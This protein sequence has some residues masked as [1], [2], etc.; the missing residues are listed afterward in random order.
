[1]V[2][3]KMNFKPRSIKGRSR[4]LYKEWFDETNQYRIVWTREVCGV[5]VPPHFF[6]TVR[7]VLPDGHEMWDFVG[8]RGPY[9]TFKKAIED[10]EANQRLWTRAM[11]ASGIRSLKDVFG[12]LPIGMPIWV[13]KKIRCDI[14]EL[15]TNTH[16]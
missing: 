1:M 6:A 9:K 12:R 5:R 13:K 3:E 15:L 16:E 11:Q 8:R 7:T 4:K 2:W 14:Y 10:C